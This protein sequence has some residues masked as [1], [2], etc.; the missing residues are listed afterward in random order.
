MRERTQRRVLAHLHTSHSFLLQ[1]PSNT[2]ASKSTYCDA[3]ITNNGLAEARELHQR[4]IAIMCTFRCQRGKRSTAENRRFRPADA[5]Y[6]WYH[7]NVYDTD[8]LDFCY[9]RYFNFHRTG[10]VSCFPRGL[11]R[12]NNFSAHFMPSTQILFVLQ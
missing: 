12:Q 4:Y 3:L 7:D 8:G 5:E 1:I 9:V 10:Q 11:S 2:H 6:Y